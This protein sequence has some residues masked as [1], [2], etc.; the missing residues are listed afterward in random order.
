L[1]NNKQLGVDKMRTREIARLFQEQIADVILAEAKKVK[2][3]NRDLIFTEVVLRN[4]GES[5]TLKQLCGMF[6]DAGVSA[7]DLPVLL[8]HQPQVAIGLLLHKKSINKML[9]KLL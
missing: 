9:K 6:V 5:I 8:P 3:T 7:E 1:V 2:K 4:I